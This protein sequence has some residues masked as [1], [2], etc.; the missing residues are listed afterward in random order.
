MDHLKLLVKQL[1][2]QLKS[3][4]DLSGYTE[5]EIFDIVIENLM[6]GVEHYK[7]SDFTRDS[8]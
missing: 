1:I 6:S 2:E 7:Y 3:E 4:T 5:S 8:N